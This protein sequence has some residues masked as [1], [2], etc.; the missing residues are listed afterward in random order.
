LHSWE[1]TKELRVRVKTP[2]IVTLTP[3]YSIEGQ[4]K[5]SYGFLKLY[6]SVQVEALANLSGHLV[7]RMNNMPRRSR[8]SPVGIPQHL[9]QRGNNRQVCFI[10]NTDCAAYAHWLYEAATKF[11]VQIHAWVFMTNHVHLLATPSE[12]G[13]LSKMMQTLGRL[14]VRYFNQTHHRTG[15][16]WE[17]RFRSCLVE[18]D[19]YF[20]Q[21]QRYIEANPLRANMVTDPGE[22]PWSSYRANALGVES[23][24]R[25]A[26][27][28]YLLLGTTPEERQSKY[29]ALFES[30]LEQPLL[31]DI[32]TATNQGLVLG[33]K[34]FRKKIEQLTGK[35]MKPGKPGPKREEQAPRFSFDN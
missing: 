31:N 15:T 27:P 29:R 20:L 22:Y 7:S 13:A 10:S 35:R 16:L 23:K 28:V 18:E 33:S 6:Y 8:Q 5:N 12:Q 1:K 9:I 4:S 25:T 17:G 24:L 14:Y 30:P 19:R 11:Q 32:R 26:H 2:P 34:L 21:C 3:N